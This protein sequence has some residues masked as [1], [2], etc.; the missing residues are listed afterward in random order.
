MSKPLNRRTVRVH[1]AD[2]D[3]IDTEINGTEAEIRSYYAV[4]STLN[5]GDG[6]G[7]DRLVKITSVEFTD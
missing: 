2:G 6:A 3:H 1:L 7:G 5:I 4:G